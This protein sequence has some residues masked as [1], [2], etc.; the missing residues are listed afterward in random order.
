MA[1]SCSSSPAPELG[2]ECELT[3]EWLVRAALA[4]DRN[5]GVGGN[6]VAKIEGPE[7]LQDL[8]DDCAVDQR[9]L[10]GA[11]QLQGVQS[12]EHPRQAAQESVRTFGFLAQGK[13]R[14][15]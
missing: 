2:L 13:L 14:I 3:A 10:V 6:P 1:F 15:V 11:C 5:I 8:F 7:V 4:P 9:Q 12:R